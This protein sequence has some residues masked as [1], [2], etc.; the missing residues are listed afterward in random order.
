M[1]LDDQAWFLNDDLLVFDGLTYTRLCLKSLTENVQASYQSESWELSSYSSNDLL[2]P[3]D[4][5]SF[6]TTRSAADTFT[7][8]WT[9]VTFESDAVISYFVELI[10]SDGSRR[11]YFTRQH[12]ISPPELRP[13]EDIT[14]RIHTLADASTYRNGHSANYMPKRKATHSLELYI[15]RF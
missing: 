13:N 14:V 7:I 2:Y 1:S 15:L 6:Q 12:F 11:E 4:I 3:P 10:M 8:E 9:P 5:W